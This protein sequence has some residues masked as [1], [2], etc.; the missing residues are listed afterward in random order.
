MMNHVYITHQ[1]PGVKMLFEVQKYF[2]AKYKV[3]T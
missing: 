2:R 1:K 3:V